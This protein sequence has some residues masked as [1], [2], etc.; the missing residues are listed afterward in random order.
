MFHIVVV[1]F[2]PWNNEFFI[3]VGADLTVKI[4]ICLQAV[5]ILEWVLRKKN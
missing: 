2:F 5:D 3:K 1:T 4:L